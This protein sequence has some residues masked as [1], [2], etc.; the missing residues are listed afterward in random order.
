M[1]SLLTLRTTRQ[2]Y[3]AAAS[4]R[5]SGCGTR[6]HPVRW[7]KPTMSRVARA[8]VAALFGAALLPAVATAAP[9][10]CPRQGGEMVFGLQA[11]VAGL[12]QHVS[13]AGSTRDVS[14]NIYES[15]VTR[16]ESLT[17]IPQLAQSIDISPDQKTFTFKLRQGVHFHN[18]KLMSSEDVLASLERYRRIGA[19]RYILEMVDHWDT[20]DPGTVVLV[21]K[22]PRPTY[23]EMLSYFSVPMVIVPKENASAP[24]QQLPAVGTGPYQLSEFVA[25]ST[26]KLR[27]FDGYTPDTR[28]DDATGFGGYKVAC[29]DSITERM[30]TESSARTAALETGEMQGVA[31]VPTASQKRL[32]DNKAVQLLRLENYQLNITFP[33]FSAPPTDNVKVRQ[34][35]EAALN[36]DEI[37]DAATDG[38]Y[39]LN[40][41]L[42]YPGTPYYS[43]AGKEF[44]NQHDP[45]KAKRLLQEAGYKGEKVVLLTNREYAFMYNTALVMSEQLKAVGVNVELQVLDWPTALQKSLSDSK[46]WNFTYTGWVTVAAL[47]G[48]QTLSNLAEPYNLY[49]PPGGKG[50]ADFNASFRE[51]N[52]APT[53]EARRA[54]FARAQARA[55]EQVMIIPFGVM[56]QVMAVRD[57][58]GGFR[59]YYHPRFYN[60]WLKN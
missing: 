24:P 46:D 11:K 3:C 50:D 57:N 30:V 44:Y 59:A 12:D 39:K 37:M 49:R 54:A 32:K 33:N 35:I 28:Y 21:L 14:I 4:C 13:P 5:R 8:V 58:V 42:Q 52:S 36:Y 47:G 55:F 38:D 40:A 6:K 19:N 53:L 56:P 51:V 1:R 25:D 2:H 23:L 29:L 48:A 43:D 31:D 9:F 20:P 15:L 7:E 34:A 41:S 26:V 10:V 27:R 17:P 22:D 45:A 60:V 16:D 18:G